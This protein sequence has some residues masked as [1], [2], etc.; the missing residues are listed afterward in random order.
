WPQ[1]E[2]M[3]KPVTPQSDIFSL[4]VVCYEALTRRHPFRGATYDEI[5]EAIRLLN[6]PPASA[7]NDA[8]S[9]LISRVVHK[10]MAKQPLY[11]YDNA[12]EFGEILQRAA[13]NAP[14]E[15]FDPARIQPRIDRAR[16]ALDSGDVPF[17]GEIVSELEASGHIDPQITELRAEVDKVVRRRTLAQLLESAQARFEE[18]EDPL[19]LQKLH[20]VLQIDP[21][22]VD[23]LGLKA[24]IEA[25]RSERQVE[26]WMRLAP[27]HNPNQSYRP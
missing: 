17:A 26:Q 27:P 6:P 15:I 19:A 16:K 13:H 22:N 4:G 10:A 14:I 8:V 2:V 3:N 23:A 25:R 5:V 18:D 1:E 24:R 7:M 20:E 12:R 9:Q 21:G 11:R